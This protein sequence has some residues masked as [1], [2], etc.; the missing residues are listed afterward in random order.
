MHENPPS[1]IRDYAEPADHKLSAQFEAEVEN[2]STDA[3]QTLQVE[4]L[5]SQILADAS[6]LL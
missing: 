5:C 2:Y 1:G 3:Y 4:A 6:F